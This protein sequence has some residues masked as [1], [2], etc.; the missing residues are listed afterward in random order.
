MI[1]VVLTSCGRFDLLE[2]TLG[3]FFKFNTAPIERFIIGEDSCELTRL[4]E[5]YPQIEF[6]Y[7]NKIGMIPNMSNLYSMVKTPYVFHMEDD[8]EFYREGFIE[9]SLKVLKSD[10]NIL[11]MWLREPTDTNGHP[12]E[13]EVLSCGELKYKLLQRNFNEVWGGYSNNPALKRISD[14]VDFMKIIRNCKTNGEHLISKYYQSAGY[15]AGIFLTG[16][17]KHIGY[18]RTV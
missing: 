14:A 6:V 7:T 18:G 11:Q 4:E 1:T 10:A 13:E 16:Y 9:D 8:W 17:V 2:R 15:R 12:L 3:T 5:I